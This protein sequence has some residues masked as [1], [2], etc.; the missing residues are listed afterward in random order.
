[1][2]RRARAAERQQ[3]VLAQALERMSLTTI[4][5]VEAGA[6]DHGRD[7]RGRPLEDLAVHVGTRVADHALAVG[8]SPI[9]SMIMRT[10]ASILA[11]ST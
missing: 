3:V 6:R 5:L 8:S 1:M 11:R 4:I 10:A 9:P 2:W 7:R